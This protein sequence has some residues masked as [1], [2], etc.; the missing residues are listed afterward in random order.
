MNKLS[1]KM[2][3]KWAF[4]KIGIV[5]TE[6][7]ICLNQSSMRTEEIE[8]LITSGL[9]ELS[10]NEWEHKDAC[11][12]CTCCQKTAELINCVNGTMFSRTEN[13]LAEII[14]RTYSQSNINSIW[15]NYGRPTGE[16]RINVFIE[17]NFQD[18]INVYDSR[19][20]LLS[21]F[22]KTVQDP[23]LLREK[24]KECIHSI[25]P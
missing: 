8:N 24:I 21:R 6:Y 7:E 5:F 4:K 14:T 17:T 23:D 12:T 3:I 19:P 10:H 18:Y 25:S 1:D 2:Y 9:T 16:I 15:I 20:V 11:E 22:S 13:P